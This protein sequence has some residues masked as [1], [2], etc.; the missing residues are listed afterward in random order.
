LKTILELLISYHSAV[1]T[2]CAAKSTKDVK[3]TKVTTKHTN[4]TTIRTKTEKEMDFRNLGKSKRNVCTND[5]QIDDTN[6]GELYEESDKRVAQ[7]KSSPENLKIN[8]LKLS[9]QTKR[10]DISN[11][12]DIKLDIEPPITSKSTFL[13]ELPTRNKNTDE[14]NLN[15]EKSHHQKKQNLLNSVFDSK[16]V[17]G[18]TRSFDPFKQNSV[19]NASEYTTRPIDYDKASKL[20]MLLFGNL[21]QSFPDEWKQQGFPFCDL[22]KLKFGIVQK[23]GGPC[24]VLASVQAYVIQELVFCNEGASPQA[25]VHMM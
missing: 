20:R 10:L 17:T 4:I 23:K 18:Q 2:N 14:E 21:S 9:S 24:G 8:N 12:Q 7:A 22:A 13:S 5:L 19:L 11:K 6:E 3:D 1:F 25:D 15:Q 16:I